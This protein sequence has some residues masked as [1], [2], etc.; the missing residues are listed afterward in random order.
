VRVKIDLEICSGHGRCH[1]KA[2]E[3]FALDEDGYAAAAE[4]DV[5]TELEAIAKVGIKSC[6]ERA[7]SAAS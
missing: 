7:I 2:A 6:P 1:A 5:P 3:V 4:I